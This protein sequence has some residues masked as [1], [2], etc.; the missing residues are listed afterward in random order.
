MS[1]KFQMECLDCGHSKNFKFN[2]KTFFSEDGD[3]VAEY[4]EELFFCHRI[5]IKCKSFIFINLGKLYKTEEIKHL[6]AIS[7]IK[8]GVGS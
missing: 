6:V 5:C 2:R 8:D 4:K 1:L 7:K 3:Y